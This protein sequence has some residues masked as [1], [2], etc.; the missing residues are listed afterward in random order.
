MTEADWLESAD[1]PL[2]LEAL[3]EL[4]G[5]DELPL[6]AALHR[7]FVASC[8]RIWKLLPQDGS[9]RGVK[10]AERYLA[11]RATDEELSEVDWH[12]EGAA[13][14]IDY[15]CDPEA[16]ERWVKQTRAMPDAELRAMLHP[17]E[18]A[19]DIDTRELLKRAAYFADYAVIYPHLMPKRGVPDSYVP[20]L[21]AGLLRELFGNPFQVKRGGRA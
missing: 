15:N 6:V 5:G 12:V 18:A 13:F 17:P 1:V 11:G 20:F 4:H 21:S 8:R 9:R 7:Y 10:I 16:I 2:M 14:N 3:W 19:L